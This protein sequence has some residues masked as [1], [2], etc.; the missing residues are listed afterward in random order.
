MS[1]LLANRTVDTGPTPQWGIAG[2]SLEL[3]ES[4]QTGN[5]IIFWSSGSPALTVRLAG[6]ASIPAQSGRTTR[7]IVA[8]VIPQF[9]INHPVTWIEKNIFRRKSPA[10]CSKVLEL[11]RTQSPLVALPASLE[12]RA[13]DSAETVVATGEGISALSPASRQSTSQESAFL[14]A[15]SRDG[16]KPSNAASRQQFLRALLEEC[17]FFAPLVLRCVRAA[18]GS[19]H[20]GA[21]QES[22]KPGSNSRSSSV[23]QLEAQ[24]TSNLLAPRPRRN[25]PTLEAEPLSLTLPTLWVDVAC[26]HMR[27]LAP[28]EKGHEYPEDPK[29][30]L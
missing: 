6:S 15:P 3:D 23:I 22:A 14:V 12:Q 10:L 26:R 30:A 11:F 13:A 7:R 1:R 19:H 17:S 18:G 2:P 16:A 29:H 27:T 24:P 20:R 21:K 5:R 9:V 25:P 8:A 28:Q 4:S